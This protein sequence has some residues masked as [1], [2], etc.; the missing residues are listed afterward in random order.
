MQKRGSYQKRLLEIVETL[1]EGSSASQIHE[2]IHHWVV[3][4]R[5]STRSLTL[6]DILWGSFVISLTDSVFYENE[7][8]LQDIRELLLGHIPRNRFTAVF[9]EDYQLYFTRDEA[10]WYE[11]LLKMVDFLLMIPFA[12]LHQAIGPALQ[13][14]ERWETILEQIPEAAQIEL[15]EQD[16]EQRKER[17]E[18]MVR[19]SSIPEN[20][21]DEAIYH[22]VLREV[23]F[24]LAEIWVVPATARAG[25]PILGGP[26]SDFRGAEL[27]QFPDMTEHI[28]WAKR[29]LEALRKEGSVLIFSWRLHKALPPDNDVLFLS[30]R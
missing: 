19:K 9:T 18:K 23:T 14:Q 7:A 3:E 28:M 30:L 10:E 16:Y 6:D 8:Y 25:Y 5:S 1:L 26:H 4:M 12:K 24:I 2:S 15:L 13:N 29:V 21:G 17:L 20:V 11:H 27:Y 22:L